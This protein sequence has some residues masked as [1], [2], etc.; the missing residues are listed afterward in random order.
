M[1]SSFAAE[2]IAVDTR[3]ECL[4][5]IIGSRGPQ[6]QPSKDVQL[7]QEGSRSCWKERSMMYGWKRTV[8]WT[9]WSDASLSLERGVVQ[10][11][12]LHSADALGL[13]VAD[14]KKCPERWTVAV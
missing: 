6:S 4:S 7:V 9:L 13:K 11:G 12:A 8:S 5:S 2:P 14:D 10:E 3:V 1:T